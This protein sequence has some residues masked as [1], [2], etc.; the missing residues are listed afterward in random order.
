MTR[1]PKMVVKSGTRVISS[2]EIR[3][4]TRTKARKRQRSPIVNPTRPESPSHTQARGEA[5]VG[6]GV[7]RVAKV[8]AP[9]RKTAMTRRIRLTGSEPTRR[10]AVWK[11]RALTVQ[12]Q[13]VASAASSPA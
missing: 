3:A 4:P 13:A 6:S 7:P 11:A 2:M 1:K 9:R 12:Q 10:P 8:K 5:S